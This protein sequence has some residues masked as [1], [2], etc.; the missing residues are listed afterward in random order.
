MNN[1]SQRGKGQRLWSRDQGATEA[2]SFE[3]SAHLKKAEELAVN[4]TRPYKYGT[5]S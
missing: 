5:G 3:A 1:P 2:E 4:M